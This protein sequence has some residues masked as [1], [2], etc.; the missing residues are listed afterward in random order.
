[1]NKEELENEE[2]KLLEKIQ[3]YPMTKFRKINR[4]AVEII[5]PAIF[6]SPAIITGNEI[7]YILLIIILVI[8]NVFQIYRQS[9]IINLYKF[10]SV[11]IL[12]QINEVKAD[13]T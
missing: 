13:K 5:P 7:F 8:F 9:K 4:Y 11:K 6:I 1:M 3:K 12:G 10:I 2:I